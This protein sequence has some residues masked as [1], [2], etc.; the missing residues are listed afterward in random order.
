MFGLTRLINFAHGQFLVLGAFVAY[1][2]V[3]NGLSFWLAIPLS[4]A[5]VAVIAVIL[6]VAV[7]RRNIDQPFNGF[8]VSLGLVIILQ[9]LI[10]ELWSPESHRINS[11]LNAVWEIGGVRITEE[12]LLLLGLT[13]LLVAALY[14]VLARTDVGRSMRAVAENR[15]AA[16]L[17]G[18]SVGLSMSLGFMMGSA[19]AA[20][21][22]AVL[23]AI[24][25]F[26]AFFGTP[27]LIKGLAA[28]LIGGLGNIEGALV[29]GLMLG[30][31]ETF[32][33][34]YG[35][36][37]PWGTFGAEWRDGYAFLLMIAVLLWRPHGL[38]RGSRIA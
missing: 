36:P 21:G 28:A 30:M 25:P 23:G 20:V 24:Y 15:E 12:R 34:A 31:I 14:Y 7:L 3:Q 9:H 33:A 19:M 16:S 27:F 17:V 11:P 13:V 6:D 4:A 18:V 1:S 35:I 22:G 26:T 5:I 2:L 32:G 37:T 8:I 38:F 10:V 29:A